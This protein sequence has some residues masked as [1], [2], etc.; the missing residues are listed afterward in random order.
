[1]FV[2]PKASTAQ[3][4][5]A[6]E[7]YLV[8][9]FGAAGGVAPWTGR[10]VLFRAAGDEGDAGE[11]GRRHRRPGRQ[12]EGMPIDQ[13]TSVASMVAASTAPRQ[14]HRHP[15]RRD[16]RRARANRAALRSLSFQAYGQTGG[17]FPDTTAAAFDKRNVR[18]GHY[19]AGRTS[20]T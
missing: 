6:E 2:V 11:P 10:D 4:I 5:S 16:L 12:V 20:S 8:F 18:D 1:M 19:S 3:A 17:Y 7:A 14:D 9:G 15:G 13:S